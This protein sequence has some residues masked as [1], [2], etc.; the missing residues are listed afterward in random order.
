MGCYAGSKIDV[1][2]TNLVLCLD[3]KNP[4]SYI[5]TGTAWRNLSLGTGTKNFTLSQT[6]VGTGYTYSGVTGFIGFRRS[7]PPAGESGGWAALTTTGTDLVASTFLYQDHTVEMWMRINDL[8]PTNHDASEGWCG[9]FINPGQHC[10]FMNYGSTAGGFTFVYLIWNGNAAT[11]A[12]EVKATTTT[13]GPIVEGRWHQFLATRSG[14]TLSCFVDGVLRGTGRALTASWTQGGA[15][16]NT[17]LKICQGN[18]TTAQF[19][20][21]PNADV[22]M[23]RCYKTVLTQ[24]QILEN[25]AAFRSRFGI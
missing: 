12:A 17:T 6:T 4:N 7:M 21:A 18:A 15:V 3:A 5:G 11:V 13:V 14:L 25:Y 19:T 8:R 1:T 16:S 23:V 9:Y 20:Y 24:A 2:T 10:G 22:A